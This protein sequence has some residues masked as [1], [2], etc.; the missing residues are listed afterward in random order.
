MSLEATLDLLLAEATPSVAATLRDVARRA[1]E[2]GYREALTSAHRAGAPAFPARAAR[3]MIAEAPPI[4]AAVRELPVVV[5]AVQA[6]SAPESGAA[7]WSTES[8]TVAMHPYVALPPTPVG[9]VVGPAAPGVWA[10]P[11]IPR[12]GDDDVEQEDAPASL[13][14]KVY[15]DQLGGDEEEEID[16]P[17]RADGEDEPDD[18]DDEAAD[19]EA[20]EPGRRQAAQNLPWDRLLVA[21]EE[22]VRSSGGLASS[23]VAV[24]FGLTRDRARRALLEL[25]DAGRIHRAG[26]RR[27]ARYAR[28]AATALR[29]SV[30]ARGSAKGP[31]RAG[32]R[33][34]DAE[35][36]GDETTMRT[37]GGRRRRVL[38][39]TP[40]R[41]T[42]TIGA[43]RARI[44][45]QLGLE[46][47]AIDVVVCKQGDAKRR[48]IRADVP[49][50]RYL[51]EE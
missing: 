32:A 44:V 31:I 22:M 21:V 1:Y 16:E 13:I 40:V 8:V 50:R 29:S 5:H 19:D 37:A 36:A 3:T 42:L 14:P 51:I 11:A 30:D 10:V 38:A 7:P 20:L 45:K 39:V 28:D 33:D 2:T 23:D 26:D 6:E 46:R 24:A 12:G 25:V 48:Q 34:D 41:V 47:F 49:L 9:Q 27:F 15:F 17:Q 4:T 43:L 18:D 35:D